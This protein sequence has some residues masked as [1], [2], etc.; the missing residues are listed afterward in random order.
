[1]AKIPYRK[2]PGKLVASALLIATLGGAGVATLT[3]STIA[4]FEGY[5]PVG[6]LDPVDIPTKC[7]GDTR[8]VVVAKEYTFEQC[9]QSINEH[10]VELIRPVLRCVPELAEQSDTTKAAVGSMVYNIGPGAFCKSSVARYF[11]DGDWERGCRRMAEI[12]KTAKGVEL[13]GLVRR[14]Q[15]ESEMCLRGLR[16]AS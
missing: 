11:N 3:L 10:M 4:D 1:M 12:Y 14:R 2:L 5:V 6:Y 15:M 7:F 16:E 8:D 9:V 13:P